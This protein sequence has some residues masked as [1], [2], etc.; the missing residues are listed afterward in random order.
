MKHSLESIKEE[1]RQLIKVLTPLLKKVL[2]A[3]LSE[4]YLTCGK[5]NCKCKEGKKHGPYLYL[6][7]SGDAKVKMHKVPKGL[8]DKV[9]EGVTAYNEVWKKLCRLC[10]IN[11]ELLWNKKLSGRYY[12]R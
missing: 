1:R 7:S 10:E 11:R 2:R 12:G 4:Y 6:S 5:K 3:T 9:R 8:E